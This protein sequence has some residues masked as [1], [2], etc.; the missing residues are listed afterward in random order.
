MASS[1]AF[2]IEPFFHQTFELHARYSEKLYQM[3]EQY[4]KESFLGQY[5]TQLYPESL[6]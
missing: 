4:F 3:M 6:E 1:R 5:K 2:D